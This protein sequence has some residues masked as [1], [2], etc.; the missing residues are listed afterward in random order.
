MNPLVTHLRKLRN[1]QPW[2]CQ[3]QNYDHQIETKCNLWALPTMPTQSIIHGIY[4]FVLNT[5]PVLL[6]GF[7]DL[8]LDAFACRN[9]FCNTFSS[10]LVFIHVC[11]L[12]SLGAFVPQHQRR[13]PL[14]CY[15]FTVGWQGT[16]FAEIGV[17]AEGIPIV[18]SILYSLPAASHHKYFQSPFYLLFLST[19]LIQIFVSDCAFWENRPRA[20]LHQCIT[21]YWT[22]V[23]VSRALVFVR[24]FFVSIYCQP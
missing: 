10:S 5:R 19:A 17:T 15:Q 14:I 9:C 12:N 18:Q 7:K 21:G 6:W 1:S 16:S 8:L 4:G 11:P 3:S 2:L 22:P 24:S 13:R 20:G 23:I